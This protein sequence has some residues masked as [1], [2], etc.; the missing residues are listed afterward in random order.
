MASK[1]KK[2]SPI[3]FV[4]DMGVTSAFYK[5]ILGFRFTLE[6]PAYF[7]LERDGQEIHLSLAS[8]VHTRNIRQG[9]TEFYVEVT[10]VQE[11]WDRV[12]ELKDHYKITDLFNRDFRMTEFHI[13]D[14]DGCLVLIGERL[15][16]TL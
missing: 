1:I 12:K 11:L 16:L 4:K 15:S 9:P 6:T 14:P 8:T 7:I 3:L 2:I 13:E 5:E 10:N